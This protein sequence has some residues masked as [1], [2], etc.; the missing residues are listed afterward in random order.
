MIVGHEWVQH[1]SYTSIT[2]KLALKHRNHIVSSL[3]KT[4][5]KS[6]ANKMIT[7]RLFTIKVAQ[8]PRFHFVRFYEKSKDSP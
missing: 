3:K 5:P 2:H 8:D 6:A 4:S 7:R 1:F